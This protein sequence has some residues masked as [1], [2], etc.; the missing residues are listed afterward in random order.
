MIALIPTLLPAGEKGVSSIA[1]P[2]NFLNPLN[3]IRSPSTTFINIQL[4][5]SSSYTLPIAII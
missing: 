4:Y 2:L 3:T 5:S 1:F